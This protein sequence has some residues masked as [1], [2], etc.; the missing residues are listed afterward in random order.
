MYHPGLALILSRLPAQDWFT[1]DEAAAH[2]GWSRSFICNR[3]KE[4]KLP[5]QSFQKDPEHRAKGKG[6]HESHRI[7]VDDLA[8]FIAKNGQGR[9]AELNP[10][11]D[12]V[13]IV[14]TWPAWMRR[15]LATVLARSLS[16]GTAGTAEGAPTPVKPGPAA[17]GPGTHLN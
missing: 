6:A 8:T 2:S 13:T 9:F 17:A 1:P 3:I 16:T 11:H 15:E 12:V 14:R 7:H 10:F 5:A 4:G